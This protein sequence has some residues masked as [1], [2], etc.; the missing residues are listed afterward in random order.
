LPKKIPFLEFFMA[1]MSQVPFEKRSNTTSPSGLKRFSSHEY[2]EGGTL[3]FLGFHFNKPI[4]L[5]ILLEIDL[6]HDNFPAHVPVANEIGSYAIAK[7]AQG[8][9]GNTIG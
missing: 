7:L 4:S 8:R 6:Y 9:V 1:C 5:L 3:V 2:V